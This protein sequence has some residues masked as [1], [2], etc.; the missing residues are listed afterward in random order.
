MATFDQKNYQIFLAVF[1]LSSKPW[2][3]FQPKMLD[4][5]PD[6]KH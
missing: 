6:P 1:F 3:G 5:D 4:P 2:I